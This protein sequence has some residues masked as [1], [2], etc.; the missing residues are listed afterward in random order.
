MRVCT[1]G[2][3]S[4]ISMSSD[5][6]VSMS[7]SS[8]G[9]RRIVCMTARNSDGFLSGGFGCWLPDASPCAGPGVGARPGGAVVGG[10][11]DVV[12]GV[13]APSLGAVADGSGVGDDAA[14]GDTGGGTSSCHR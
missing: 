12:R 11:G 5:S 8:F 2:R 1:A 3:S 14:A 4:E 6:A 9:S 13:V 10:G 7:S